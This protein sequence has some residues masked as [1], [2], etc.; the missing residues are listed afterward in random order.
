MN[1][2]L[3]NIAEV[4]ALAGTIMLESHAESYRV[5]DTVRRILAT[6]GMD[7]IDVVT[8]TTGLYLTLD[9]SDPSMDP[10]TIVRRIDSRG[11]HL[12]KIYRVNNISRAL[13]SGQISHDEAKRRLNVVN[14]SEYNVYS[15]DIATILLVVAFTILGG[16]NI[17][18]IILSFPIG[19]VVALSRVWKNFID[20]N[21]FIF[22]MFTTILTAFATELFTNLFPGLN[23]S[24]SIIIIAALMP[25]YPGTAFTNGIRDTLKGDYVSGVAR[26]ADAFVIALSIALGV[27]LGLSLYGGVSAWI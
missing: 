8:N 23:M 21:D 26:I 6:S 5:E 9:D 12:N 1:T 27:A 13:T 10:I 15:L 24:S 20:M 7:S 3:K 4:A 25:L 17:Y 2:E 22:T 11:N 18:D 19:A 16:G 14:E